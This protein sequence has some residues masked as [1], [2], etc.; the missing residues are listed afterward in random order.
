MSSYEQKYLK[1]KQK[2]QDLKKQYNFTGGSVHQLETETADIK[3]FTLSDTPSFNNQQNGGSGINSEDITVDIDYSLSDTPVQKGGSMLS[4]A[5]F[6]PSPLTTCVGQVNPM[7]NVA[8]PMT[9]VNTATT[10]AVAA[11]AQPVAQP[12]A[13]IM[14][15]QNKSLVVNNNNTEEL[16]TTTDLS[17]IRNTEDIEKLF[18]QFGGKRRKSSKKS[19]KSAFLTT[20]SESDSESDSDISSDSVDVDFDM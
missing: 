7:P 13:P 5:S 3:D 4:P 9:V 18:H 12:I 2:Y 19:K 20:D 8:V 1:Y 14:A 6:N 10:A 15:T 16:V 11:V 17:E